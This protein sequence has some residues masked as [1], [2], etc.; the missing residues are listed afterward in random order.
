MSRKYVTFASVNKS[1]LNVSVPTKLAKGFR[2]RAKESGL[3]SNELLTYVLCDLLGED[4]VDFGLFPLS[5]RRQD[6][7]QKDDPS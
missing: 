5:Q 4:P 2:V 1:P 7:D 6:D 3:K